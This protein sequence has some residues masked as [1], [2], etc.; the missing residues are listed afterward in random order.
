MIATPADVLAM[1]SLRP[2]DQVTVIERGMHVA[3]PVAWSGRRMMNAD[4]FGHRD[5]A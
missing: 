1:G 4:C 3:R 2:G 5:Q